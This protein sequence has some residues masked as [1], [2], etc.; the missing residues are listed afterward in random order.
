MSLL[1][2]MPQAFGISPAEAT[3]MDPQQRLLLHSLAELQASDRAATS[4]SHL[5]PQQLQQQQQQLGVYVG[6]SQLE[7]ARVCLEHNAP[8]TAY[9]ATGGDEHRKKVKNMHRK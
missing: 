6:V 7:Y 8:L 5:P 9:Y 1:N 4:A 2:Q 3:L